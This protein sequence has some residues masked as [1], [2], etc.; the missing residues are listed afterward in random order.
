[1]KE[2]HFRGK[3]SILDPS[4]IDVKILYNKLIP[5]NDQLYHG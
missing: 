4:L 2:K 3:K 1:M 5:R